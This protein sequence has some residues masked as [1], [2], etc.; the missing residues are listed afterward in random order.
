MNTDTTTPTDSN[1]LDATQNG[2]NPSVDHGATHADADGRAEYS[3][4]ATEM[5]LA[6][7]SPNAEAA[8]WRR[9]L[10]DTETELATAR[11]RITRYQRTEIERLAAEHLAVPADLF[12]IG[13]AD[14]PALLDDNGDPD[15]VKVR[16]A[17]D[18]LVNARPGLHKNGRPNPVARHAN[19]G[20]GFTGQ[21]RGNRSGWNEMIKG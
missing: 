18:E 4:D 7:D 1:P 13:K 19:Y 2:E 21:T 15:P 9:K 3:G 11:E 12:D 16:A 8:K 14:L 5:E 6:A 20:Q 10:R 17:V